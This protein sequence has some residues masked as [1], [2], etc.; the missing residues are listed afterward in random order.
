MSLLWYSNTWSHKLTIIFSLFPDFA[1]RLFTVRFCATELF[2]DPV[3]VT[4]LFID[5]FCATGFLI[6]RFWAMG[7]LT[8]RF[9]AMVFLI[10]WFCATVSF[11]ARFLRHGVI[12]SP[13][14]RHR[15][16]Y[17]LF[18]CLACAP[19]GYILPFCCPTGLFIARFCAKRLVSATLCATGSFIFQFCAMPGFHCSVLRY[20]AEV[21]TLCK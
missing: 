16:F 7:F 18:Y 9:C 6:A 13:I 20:S 5:R 21:Y 19:W 11:I 17:F 15:D 2:V 1:T 10:A 14:L 12:C 3:C 4:L 8:A